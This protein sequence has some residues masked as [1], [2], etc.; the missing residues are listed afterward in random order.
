ME[1]R[2]HGGKGPPLPLPS[3]RLMVPP[4]RLV[5][6]AIW[7]TIQ[8][9][10][11]MDYGMLEEFVTM[12]T[13][14]VP[15]LLNL[16]QRAQ[17]ILG[18]RARLVLELCRSKPISDLQTIQ[19]HLDRIQTLTPLWGTQATDAEVGL[20]ES[21]FLGLVQTLLKDPDEREHFFQAS[22]LL[23][24]VP[25]VLEE[26]VESVSDPQ[27]L[28]TL[29]QYHRDLGPLDNHDPPSSTDGD[30]IL[31]ALCLPPVERVVIATE[32]EKEGKSMDVK[33][34]EE[35]MESRSEECEKNKRSSVSDEEAEDAAEF[36]DQVTERDPEYETVMVIGED[37][38][39]K[40]FKLLKKHPQKKEETH[41]QKCRTTV[42]PGQKI[43][44]GVSKA[45][46]SS[47]I[48]KPSVDLQGV[49]IA[50]VTQTPK[51]SQKVGRAKRSLERRTCKVCGKVVQRPA[52]L[53]KHMVTHTGDWPYQCPTCKKI[54]KTL[55]SFQ[56]HTEK[57]VFPIEE[58]PEESEPSI[59]VM[60]YKG[61]MLK[62]I[63]PRPPG[64]KVGQ[65]E[66]KQKRIVCKTCP[67]CGKTLA[68]SS[69]MKRH[70]IIHTEPK[71]CRVCEQVFP[72]PS[73]LKIHMESHPKKGIHQCSNCE[74]T[75]KHDYSV[76]AH[77][78]ACLFLS[79]QQG[80]LGESSGLPA[81]GQTDPGPSGSTHQQ[82]VTCEAEIL[83]LSATLSKQNSAFTYMHSVEGSSARAKRSLERRT[84]KVCGKVVQRPA[85][86]RKHMVTHTGDWPYRCPTC[87]KI[88]KTLRSF[89]K[90]IERCVFPIEE[91][92]K[93]SE[94]SSIN[95]TE[96]SSPEPSAPIGSSKR[97][98]RCPICHKF[99]LGYLRYHILS[100][101]DER[102][103][104]CPRCGSKY[105]FD[106]VLR[107]HMRLFCKV[108]KGEPVELGEKK[109]HKCNECG[110]EFGL[111]S[112][113]TAH[114]RIHNPLRCAYCRR[115]FPD[116]ETLAIHKVEHK[117]VQCTMCEKS[118][119][120]IR[121]LSRHY[122][123]DHQFSGPFRC[124]YC[125]RSYADLAALIRHQRIHT[126]GE[127]PYKCAHCPKKFHFETALVTHQ[128]NHTG[129]KPCL[130][131]EC[132]KTF[133]SKGI[134]KSH[135]NRVHT[136][137]VK[138][139]P[140]S[141][142]NKVFRDKGQMKMHENV[143]H[144]GVRYPCSYC[145]KGFYSPAPLARHV[146]IHTGENPY[147]CTYKECTRVFKSASELRIHMRYHTGERPFKCKDCGKGFVQAH[148]LTIHRRSHTG[149]KPYP[150]LTCDKSFGTSHQLSRHMKTHTGEKPYQC[151]DCG[152]A[153]NRRDRLRTHQ[154]KCHPAY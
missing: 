73:E 19:P 113:L 124:T 147:S 79:R 105:K 74:R 88:Y 60:Q 115:M 93:D 92:P 61:L 11:V 150:C 53:R 134:L 2:I 148:Y 94:S 52:V 141:Q 66:K 112:T 143:Y 47:M 51:L 42:K 152:K 68:T 77:E 127:P 138:R 43:S 80:E 33:E 76:K 55:G 21:N 35:G 144:K 120:V 99:I 1:R 121:Y 123:D 3:L 96:S 27:Q 72:N 37:G 101:S 23:G 104:A 30:C 82:S 57:C 65:N 7:Q 119:N 22:S 67:V 58:T 10:H 87:K 103:H 85:V 98:A 12:V 90:H 17:L 95:A 56:E 129:E 41:D 114:K 83:Q 36:A 128:R 86:L 154:D 32:V 108:K 44:I 84:C 106:F 15:E 116:Q 107:R 20:S 78:E 140:C 31:S 135:M 111:K 137:Q 132:G 75:F 45:I 145:G 139:I 50:N 117:P 102:P 28:K 29:L 18:L 109:V 64:Q 13:E 100:H 118:F 149:E 8:Q 38:I 40:P 142:C 97:C 133:Q 46:M 26:C 122:V 69:S 54:Y 59:S 91:T 49:V 70:Q 25:S 16:R 110:K 14:M 131:W 136:P 4:L 48:Q 71:K 62:K 130:C 9:R 6:A 39:E 89:Q 153:F 146:L 5:S 126:G 125:E 151:M 34:S 81:T 24:D 63:L